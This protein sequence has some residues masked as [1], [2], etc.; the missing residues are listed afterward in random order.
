MGKSML[1]IVIGLVIFALG[2]AGVAALALPWLVSTETVQTAIEREL[3][4][5]FG[6]SAELGQQTE[7]VLFPRPRARL[8]DVTIAAP[9]GGAP[10]LS[11]ESME[12]DIGLAGLLTG[13]PRF[14]SFRLVRPHMQLT[15]NENAEIDWQA[16]SGRVG[17]L[18]AALNNTTTDE[19]RDRVMAAEGQRL[20][21]ISSTGGRL[22]VLDAS[23]AIVE[24][25]TSID[26]QINWPSILSA[27]S[28][29]ADAIWRGTSAHVEFST[30]LPVAFFGNQPAPT[31]LSVNSE[32]GNLAFDGTANMGSMFF[33]DGTMT[34]ATP[35]MRA[36]MSIAGIELAPGRALGGVE[37]SGPMRIAQRR[38][39]FDGLDLAIDGNNGTGVLEIALS[40]AQAEPA[41]TGTLD[42]QSLDIYAFLSAFIDMS[43]LPMDAGTRVDDIVSRINTDLRI[44]AADAS[45]G[46]LQLT[47]L[48]ATA[49]VSDEVAIFDVGDAAAYGGNVQAR[50]ALT[51]GDDGGRAEVILSGQSVDSTAI[52]AMFAL[53]ETLP[54]G[55]GNFAVT[56]SAPIT[57]R[58]SAARAAKGTVSIEMN[59]GV[60]PGFGLQTLTEPRDAGRY[61]SLDPDTV[62]ETFSSA[63]I[64]GDIDDGLLTLRDTTVTY[65]AGEMLLTGI[66]SLAT[67][68][69]ALTA[70]TRRQSDDQ[71]DEPE[72]FEAR[73][74]VGG[75]WNRPFAT[76]VLAPRFQID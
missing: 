21:T 12:T 41:L 4:S 34:F 72:D 56:V 16:A 55:R 62:S 70:H 60:M 13:R 58:Y 24:D 11:V 26:G 57:D 40:R 44:S 49:Q 68:S 47:D 31:R 22:T 69:L 38:I 28:L 29:S 75:S 46:Q 53:P 66:V 64:Y 52:D 54:R 27:V 1:R 42:F 35:S 19:A 76:P 61:F 8:T 45:F 9:D 63:R 59:D 65:P 10:L 5:F 14:S 50:L 71:S 39:Q 20:G 18:I 6:T 25:I 43:Q 37:M 48:A 23:G 15:Q 17:R 36:L 32:T 33:A 74:F 30:Q 67:G 73:F 7:L 2:A 3:G 51:G